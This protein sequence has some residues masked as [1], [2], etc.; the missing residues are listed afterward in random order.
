MVRPLLAAVLAATL[1][2]PVG[3]TAAQDTPGLGIAVG[4][5]SLTD[6][7]PRY[8][9]FIVGP[10]GRYRVT[11]REGTTV[12]DLVPWTAHAAIA[13]HPSGEANVKLA[14]AVVADGATVRFEVNGATVAELP[15]AAVQPDGVVGLRVDPG[16]N[17]HVATLA[18]GERNVAP[19][20][21]ATGR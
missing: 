13:R 15:R 12:R 3:R 9:A 14:L 8:T 7:A 17:A 10:D 2:A 20:L 11:R 18:L 16:V 1:L 19:V 4:G 6:G 5:D 21:A